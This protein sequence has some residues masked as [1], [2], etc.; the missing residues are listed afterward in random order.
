MVLKD[1]KKEAVKNKPCVFFSGTLVHIKKQ[2]L[3]NLNL[4]ETNTV[5]P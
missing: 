5:S 3:W 4:F 2:P 1:K